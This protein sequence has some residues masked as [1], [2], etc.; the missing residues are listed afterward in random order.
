MSHLI[1]GFIGLLFTVPISAQSVLP[2]GESDINCKFYQGRLVNKILDSGTYIYAT[3]AH[4]SFIEFASYSAG[5]MRVKYRLEKLSSRSAYIVTKT[6]SRET[7][8][9]QTFFL[10]V[11]SGM[12]KKLT[13]K[14]KHYKY[15]K[16]SNICIDVHLEES[17][18]LSLMS[19]FIL[20]HGLQGDYINFNP[21]SFVAWLRI[22]I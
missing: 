5:R 10:A 7:D 1:L 19:K 4:Y 12:L 14:K 16:D 21:K 9:N 8:S 17:L 22:N 2:Q 3:S 6:Y 18:I 11:D 13:A 15:L 20:E